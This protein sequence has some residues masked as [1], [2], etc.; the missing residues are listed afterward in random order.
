YLS[1]EEALVTRE[2]K[3]DQFVLTHLLSEQLAKRT[4][5][6]GGKKYSLSDKAIDNL[7]AEVNSHAMNLGLLNANERLYNHLMY[8]ISV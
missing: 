3:F 7:I 8:G 1:P 6:F 5:T 4:F 2:V